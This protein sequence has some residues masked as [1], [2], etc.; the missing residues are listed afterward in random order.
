MN[1]KIKLPFLVTMFLCFVIHAQNNITVKGQVSSSEDNEPIP[2]VNIVVANSSIGAVTDFDGNFEI[3]AT[4]G[5]L[6]QFSYVGFKTQVVAV[7]TTSFLN[8]VMEYDNTL[9]DEIVVIGYGTQK[10]KNLTGAISKVKNENLD[11]IAVSRVDDA[12]TGQVSG[13][14]IQATEGEA[15]SDPTIRVRGTGSITSSS[16]P[17]IVVDG[18][19]VDN[20]FL[21]N[22][23]MNDIESF[24][25]LKDASSAAI[26]GARGGNGVILISTKNGK[27]GRTKFTYN[28]YKGFKEARIGENIY[29]SMKEWAKK[30]HAATGDISDKTYYKLALRNDRDWQD[31]MFDGGLIESHSFSARGGSQRTT[32]STSLNY[33]S[34]EGVLLTDNFNRYSIRLKVDSRVGD[35]FK[36]GANISPSYSDRRRFDGSTHD[37]LRQPPWLPVYHNDRTIQFVDRNI[38]PDVQ[39]GDYAVQRH[40]DNFDLYGDGGETDISTT[41]NTNPAAKILERDRNDYKFKLYGNIYVQYEITDGLKFKTTLGGDY[42]HTKR[43][44]W[45]GIKASRNGV[46]ATRLDLSNLKRL[47]IVSDN[48]FTY[49][50]TIGQHDIN[51]VGGFS[52]EQWDYEIE[53]ATGIGY[54]SDL[55]RTLSAATTIAE[56]TSEEYQQR[57]MS[58]FGRVNYAYDNKYLL[59]ISARKD[60]YSAFG[61]D[62]KYG[63]FPAVSAGWTLSNE[64][65]LRDSKMINY[66][67]LRASYGL[68][69]NNA[70]D[71]GSGDFRNQINSYPYLSL[72]GSSSAS[73]NNSIVN[74]FNPLNISNASLGWEKSVEVNP[75]IDF[76]LFNNR[77]TGSIDVYRRTSEDLLLDVPVSYTTGFPNALA[78][79]GKVENRGIEIELKTKNVIRPSFQWNSTF[80]ASRN[81]NELLDFAESDGLIT[82]VDTKRAAEWINLVGNPISSFYGWVVDTEIPAEYI[83]SPWERVRQTN[84]EVY[85]KDLNGDGVIDEDDKTILGNPYPD[86]VWSISNEFNVGD[87]DLSFIFQGSHGAEVRNIGDQYLFRHFGS[88]AT[89][90]SSAPNQGFI[91]QKIF[92]DSIVQN[93]SYVALRTISIGYDFP[94]DLLSGLFITNARIYATGQNLLY[95]TADDYNGLNPESIYNTSPINYGYQRVGSPINQTFSLGFNLNF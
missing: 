11:K 68:T 29:V 56:A 78:N 19:V 91:K 92:T 94:E 32:F 22:L 79:R 1:Y 31:I 59:S 86:L 9:L 95:I 80:I 20:D 42:S 25:V 36:V 39:V 71:I 64:D 10:R 48:I 61:P 6:L 72:I 54:T 17:L 77:L 81:E 46:A 58:Y 4:E 76:G 43:D 5:D 50:K 89:A 27:E 90:L 12:L 57:L 28:T 38:Y 35:K 3:N 23:D 33:L 34:D 73:F 83:K 85:V 44:R 63:F 8:I 26:F 21:G 7:G 82:N 24:E 65:Y 18:I 67:K 37:V 53:S 74:G 75:G 60:G 14:N 16:S 87:F 88:S 30:E 62:S 49:D 93:A 52:V 41:S 66:L 69:G 15:G 40:F 2:G 45:Q 70:F 84:R 55:V 47:H 13:V 51:A